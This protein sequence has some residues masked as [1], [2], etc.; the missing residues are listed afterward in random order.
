MTSITFTDLGLDASLLSALES[1]GYQQP[2][3]VQQAAI[4][5]LLSGKDLMASAQTGTGKT[6]AFILPTLHRLRQGHSGSQP[7][8]LVLAPTREL[9]QQVS[10]AAR[11]YGQGRPSVKLATLVG[12]ASFFQQL[13]QLDRKPDLII[14]TPGRLLDHVRRGKLDLSAIEVLILDEADRMLDLGFQDEVEAIAALLPY[15]RQTA[16]FSATLEGM[17]AELAQGLLNEPELLSLA[18]T[19]VSKAS[20]EQRMHYVD[21]LAHKEQLLD[22]WLARGDINQAIIFTA[23]RIDA[24]NLA[25]RLGDQGIASGALHGDMAQRDRNHTLNLLRRNQIKV[26]VATDVAARGI[27]VAGISHVFNFDLPRSAE[28]YVHRIGRTG[29]AGAQGTAVSLVTS[30]EKA[31]LARIQRLT[32]IKMQAEVLPGLEPKTSFHD[33]S[34]GRRPSSRQGYGRS[35]PRRDSSDARFDRQ[36]RQSTDSPSSSYAPKENRYRGAGDN[37]GFRSE[38]RPD[39]SRGS[40]QTPRRQEGASA[41]PRRFDE[42]RPAPRRQDG[43]TDWAPRRFDDQRSAPR[44]QEG[45]DWSARRHDESRGPRRGGSES[46]A[47]RSFREPRSETRGRHHDA[48]SAPAL[49]QRAEPDP[50]QVQARGMASDLMAGFRRR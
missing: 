31:L 5:V 49:R 15:K 44:R 26:L 38:F 4:P 29:R 14:A 2:T 25:E 33:D 1:A 35:N 30:R 40:Y 34:R 13:R 11:K 41:A 9:A 48:G 17:V 50:A 45:S 20:I 22:H 39:D 24:Q 18:P 3:P 36:V 19:G 43:A 42:Q 16:L 23:T 8:G 6:A 32:G 46:S 47:E 37:K 27:D 12:G 21:N 10:D 28:D 7:R